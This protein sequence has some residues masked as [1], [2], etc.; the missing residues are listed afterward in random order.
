M[1]AALFLVTKR[2]LLAPA[3]TATAVKSLST[4]ASKLTP[5]ETGKFAGFATLPKAAPKEAKPKA[6][7]VTKPAA[8]RARPAPFRF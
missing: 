5:W 4:F 3:P 7:V 2:V 1:S 8:A 6:A